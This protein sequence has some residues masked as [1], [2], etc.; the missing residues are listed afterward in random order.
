MNKNGELAESKINLCFNQ[1]KIKKRYQAESKIN[2][3]LNQNKKKKSKY[4]R[5]DLI[6]LRYYKKENFHRNQQDRSGFQ[7]IQKF[8]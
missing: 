6:H 5:H 8:V 4:Q 3:Y 1:N 2:L 7:K